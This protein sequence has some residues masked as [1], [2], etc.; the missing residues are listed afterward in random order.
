MHCHSR[1]NSTAPHGAKGRNNSQYCCANNVA[2][3]SV[4][5]TNATTPNK[6]TRNSMQQAVQT[7]ATSNIQQ[8][9]VRLHRALLK[10]K[11]RYSKAPRKRTQHCWML[12]VASV[13]TPCCMLL[14]FVAQ[15]L[16]PVKLLAT[17]KRTQQRNKET[18]KQTTYV[19][20]QQQKTQLNNTMTIWRTPH[21][22]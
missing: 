21:M 20:E 15:S 19:A 17:L 11:C 8:C 2:C 18:G 1:Q 4:V 10:Q 12:H 16:K 7:D 5:K 3:F 22:S 14:L 13:C 6:T 9:C